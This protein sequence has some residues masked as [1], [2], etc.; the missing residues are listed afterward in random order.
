MLLTGNPLT[1]ATGEMVLN[2]S[3]GLGEAAVSGI[4]QPDEYTLSS[5]SFRVKEKRM[6]TKMLKILR[7]GATGGGTITDD[8][9]ESDRQ[10]FSLSDADLATLGD[11]GSRV[12][13]YHGGIPQAIEWGLAG[14]ELFLLQ[15][16]PITAVDIS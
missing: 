13:D 16:R 14:G 9:P 1:A 8:V 6:G 7:A 2:A 12:T 3:W 15:S 11:L 5:D 4:V 10:R